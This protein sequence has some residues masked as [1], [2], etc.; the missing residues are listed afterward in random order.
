M[1][2]VEIRHKGD[3]SKTENFLNNV[4]NINFKSKFATYGEQGV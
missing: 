4:K 3:L 2:Q 1:L